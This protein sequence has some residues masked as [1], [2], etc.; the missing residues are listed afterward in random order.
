MLTAF[1]ILIFISF[2]F[3]Y[4]F[5]CFFITFK[6]VFLLTKK[7]NVHI[8]ARGGKMTLADMKQNDCGIISH[9]NSECEIKRRLLDLGFIKGN[10]VKFERKNIF[11]SPIAF[12][13]EGSVVALRKPDA[14]KVGVIL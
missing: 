2:S 5:C 13:I 6:C 3:L 1:F 7:H 10:E 4:F 14:E 9:I 12:N 8:I 11:G